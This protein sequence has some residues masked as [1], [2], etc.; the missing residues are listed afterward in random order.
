MDYKKI[1]YQFG[2]NTEVMIFE[3]D[4]LV[5]FK[6]WDI[7]NPVIK[8]Y[9][10][11]ENLNMNPSTNY[12]WSISGFNELRDFIKAVKAEKKSVFDYVLNPIAL[13]IF[14]DDIFESER[15]FLRNLMENC[16]V[17]EIYLFETIHVCKL[18]VFTISNMVGKK[19]LC[20][21]ERLHQSFM[22]IENS[23]YLENK[24]YDISNE[25]IYDLDFDLVISNKS[26]D[27]TKFKSKLILQG[28][29]LRKN[30]IQG[31]KKYIEFLKI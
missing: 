18:N 21:G 28:D 9:P 23:K 13:C 5:Y 20:L 7:E 2:K 17:R 27:K 8:K 29:E 25:E 11:I 26:I 3:N 16:N 22:E 14:P 6:L 24:V 31:S 19:I 10:Y 15:F 1:F 30:L 12:K 4:S